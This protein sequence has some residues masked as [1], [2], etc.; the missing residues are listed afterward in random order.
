[1]FHKEDYY[2]TMWNASLGVSSR[3]TQKGPKEHKVVSAVTRAARILVAL[4]ESSSALTLSDLTKRVGIPKS[5]VLRICLTLCKSGLLVR[6]H[7]GRF[8]LGPLCLRLGTA[9]QNTF[10]LSDHVIPVLQTLV[11]KTGE[12]ASFFI[13]EGDKRICLFRVDSPKMVRVF[14]QVGDHF[15]LDRGAAG[16]VLLAFSNAQTADSPSFQ[17]IRESLYAVSYG[18]RDPEVAAVACPV[19][20]RD[21]VLVGA[22]SVAGPKARFSHA[23]I[24]R[25][26]DLV[27]AEAARLTAVLGGDP[28]VFERAT[29]KLRDSRTTSQG[30]EHNG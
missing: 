15:P 17:E 16:K 24:Q 10:R 27:R 9:Y 4:A 12:S 29:K 1:M 22:I 3:V 23:E 8:R 2:A 11:Q 30:G 5:T 18:E 13:R 21:Q 19:F 14:S 6:L 25:A 28:T 26:S 20:G 7:D